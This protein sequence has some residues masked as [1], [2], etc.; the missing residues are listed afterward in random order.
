[1]PKCEDI[2][3]AYLNYF[4]QSKAGRVAIA[5]TSTGTVLRNQT[6]SIKDFE[7]LKVPLP[8]LDEQRRIA[9]KLDVLMFRHNT[10]T[11]LVDHKGAL[12]AVQHV[13]GW[14]D[15]IIRRHSSGEVAIKSL[16]EPV[17]DLVHPG[18]DA[19]PAIEFVGLEHV[20]PHLGEQ[21]GGRPVGDEKGRKFRFQPGD[22]LYGYLRPYLNKVWATDR[23]GLCSVE[24]FVLRPRAGVPPTILSAQLRSRTM[25]EQVNSLTNNLQLPRIRLGALLDLKV[26][27]VPPDATEALT[28][29]LE[30]L[31][32]R[33][34]RLF[35]AIH[36]RNELVES[37]RPAILNAAFS[38]QL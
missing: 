2:N 18:D 34:Q 9:S 15:T 22:V 4:F 21:I 27:S 10:V 7:E 17:T 16:C 13:P 11:R 37:L 38:N 29:D 20:A 35:A 12:P 3:L 6:L 28:S 32:W 14:V 1:V 25:L 24:Q 19:G 8:G 30:L 5:S 23:H 36:K 31:S 26:P 33:A